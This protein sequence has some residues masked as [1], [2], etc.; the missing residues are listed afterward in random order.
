MQQIACTQSQSHTR[1]TYE[2]KA[3]CM[4]KCFLWKPEAVLW[5]PEVVL[6]IA[7]SSLESW[8]VAAYPLRDGLAYGSWARSSTALEACLQKWQVGLDYKETLKQVDLELVA[9][10]FQLFQLLLQVFQFGKLVKWRKLE[11]LKGRNWSQTEK[12]EQN[13]LSQQVGAKTETVCTPLLFD[14]NVFFL[15]TLQIFLLQL[16]ASRLSVRAFSLRYF[17]CQICTGCRITE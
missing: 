10:S 12:S 16:L 9:M 13:K 15:C 2:T 3:L 17:S 6:L 8:A 5:A 11:I 14:S 4:C 1:D 7:L